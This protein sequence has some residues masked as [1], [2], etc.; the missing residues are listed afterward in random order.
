[1]SWFY[2]IDFHAPDYWLYYHYGQLNL[3]AADAFSSLFIDLSR[4]VLPFPKR[5]YSISLA[6][7]TASLFLII[8]SIRYRLHRLG[9]SDK[10]AYLFGFATLSMGFWYYG[11]GKL[12]YDFPFTIA[13]SSVA[14]AMLVV[15]LD[16]EPF[17][18]RWW[19]LFFLFCGFAFSW[20]TYNVFTV[21]GLIALAFP[22]L[23]AAI[24]AAPK[25]AFFGAGIPLGL[26][27]LLGMY[28][29]LTDPIA[30]LHGIR[31]YGV[32]VSPDR[33]IQHIVPAAQFMWV[34]TC[35]HVVNAPFSIGI[36]SPVTGIILVILSA[37]VSR[38]YLG[39][40]SLLSILYG[41]FIV[42]FSKGYQWNGFPFGLI[43]LFIYGFL[44]IQIA[45]ARSK[46]KQTWFLGL[47]IVGFLITAATTFGYYLP[48][49]IAIHQATQ[50][51]ITSLQANSQDLLQQVTKFEKGHPGTP[52]YLLFDRRKPNGDS[53][54]MQVDSRW[55][56]IQ[57]P[58]T[59][60]TNSPFITITPRYHSHN[61]DEFGNPFWSRYRQTMVAVLI[62][63]RHFK[64]DTII[65]KPTYEIVYHHPE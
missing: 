32:L 16:R 58:L 35:D 12:F 39:L 48:T 37:L 34:H 49:Q 65:Q 22:P 42:A 28:H 61:F 4:L 59:Y 21:F 30:T 14:L 60:P 24:K 26:G 56:T 23:W 47:S 6:M 11:A 15:A 64:S 13:S 1:M 31:G 5:A 46:S 10:W 9:H 17:P 18:T 53:P 40:I 51:A 38:Y 19:A 52:V 50:T 3:P 20:K 43:L 57:R 27:Y 54:L 33:L 45:G 62:A 29:L 2:Q 44:C 55:A 7:M 8:H 41:I 63:G 25:T 36:L